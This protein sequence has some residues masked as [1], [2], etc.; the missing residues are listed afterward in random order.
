MHLSLA[1]RLTFE[2]VRLVDATLKLAKRGV[3]N[4]SRKSGKSMI[5][6]KRIVHVGLASSAL[7][8]M[9]I[10]EPLF[11][12][13]PPVIQSSE[14]GSTL[15]RFHLNIAGIVMEGHLAFEE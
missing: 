2:I 1:H 8:L 6:P 11:L 5:N 14:E 9:V 4:P 3:K 12:A 13:A 15:L 10:S 7:F